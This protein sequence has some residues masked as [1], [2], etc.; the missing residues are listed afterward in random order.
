MDALPRRVL[1]GLGA[2]ASALGAGCWTIGGPATTNGGIPIGWDG[3]NPD[4]AYAGLVRAHELGVS[5]FD[6]ADVYGLGTSERLLGRLLRTL[7]RGSVVVS[8]KVGYFAGTAHHPYMPAQMRHQFATTLDNLGTDYVDIYYLHSSD[9]GE[10]DRYLPGAVEIIAQLR[11]QGLIRAVGIRAPHIFAEEWA[12]SNG[13]NAAETARFLRLFHTIHPEVVTARYNLLSPLYGHDETDIFAFTRRHGAGVIIKQALR[14]GLLVKPDLYALPTFSAADHRS[15]D[16]EF[17]HHALTALRQRLA[18]I[19]AR[20]G[21]TPAEMAR[22]ALRYVLQTA[23]DSPVLVGFR[24][25]D[26]IHTTVTSLGD[27]LTEDDIAGIRATLHPTATRKEP[28]S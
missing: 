9:F 17:H 13:A 22:V 19:R 20:F 25:A 3:V 11:A 23:P 5:L 24:N 10:D 1:P 4:A 16:P 14:Q 8:S 12:A 21:D 6:T 2:E 27:P 28:V 26:Q 7:N 18:P 15:R